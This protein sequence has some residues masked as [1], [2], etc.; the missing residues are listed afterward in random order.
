MRADLVGFSGGKNIRGPQNSELIIGRKDLIE[1]C[2][3]NSCPNNSIGRPMK[4]SKETIVGLVKAL[5]LYLSQDFDAEME[6]WSKQVDY[7]VESLFELSCVS[8]TRGF[9]T[10]SVH[11][12][13]P[14]CIPK[15]YI[16]WDEEGRR[17]KKDQVVDI[18]KK[19][20]PGIAVNPWPKRGIALNPRMLREG[21]REN[22]DA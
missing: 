15:A 1:A 4:I 10:L 18:L 16:V 6:K 9:P 20:N 22:S 12:M 21:G 14:V 8:V 7:W 5:E 11:G 3:L 19:G 13:G 17:L 2:T